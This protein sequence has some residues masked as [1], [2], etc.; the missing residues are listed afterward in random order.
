MFIILQCCAFSIVD[1]RQPGHAFKKKKTTHLMQTPTTSRAEEKAN[2]SD[3][4]LKILQTL[5]DINKRPAGDTAFGELVAF[6]INQIADLQ[7]RQAVKRKI[8]NIIYSS[9]EI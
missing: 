3:V 9:D 4:D 1:T 7:K 8:M 5:S 6:E 2:S